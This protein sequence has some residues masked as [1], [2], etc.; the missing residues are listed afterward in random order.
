MVNAQEWLNENYP[1]EKRKNLIKLDID[2]NLDGTLVLEG[3]TH[4]RI[5]NCIYSRLANLDLS[6]CSRLERLDCSYSSLTHLNLSCCP[7]MIEIRCFSKIV[8]LDI[9]NCS[10]LKVLDCS[11][12][13][14]TQ[15][16]IGIEE[17]KELTYFDC[18]NNN[19]SRCE[20]TIFSNL[21]NLESLKLGTDNGILDYQ[22]ITSRGSVR[23]N[24]FFGSLYSLRNLNKLKELEIDNTDI[25]QGLEHL[26]DSLK[27]IGCDLHDL[28]DG[29]HPDVEKIFDE[30]RGFRKDCYNFDFQAWKLVKLRGE[31]A[32]LQKRQ[33]LIELSEETNH[34]AQLQADNTK[35]KKD[36]LNLKKELAEL[37]SKNSSLQE[38]TE[39]LEKEMLT[40][41]REQISSREQML[42]SI[43][44]KEQ[45][46]E[47]LQEETKPLQKQ[48]EEKQ[49]L[50]ARTQLPC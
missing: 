48:L 8:D 50:H 31:L 11:S 42:R 14:L 1:K 19:I 46:K 37:Q 36:L 18:S 4:L 6:D 15:L 38:K 40:S 47:R 34:L 35:L 39:K 22:L 24:R 20:I 25:D 43:S 44:N 12:N 3:F 21:V 33:Q 16:P 17:T 10:K 41:L 32:Q 27:V 28:D 45:V 5:L 9:S 49:D 2:Y 23:Y 13:Y 26:P 29:R 7:N 30:M